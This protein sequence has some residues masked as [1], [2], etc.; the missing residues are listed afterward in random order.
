M[1]KI[2]VTFKYYWIYFLCL[3]FYSFTWY[4]FYVSEN[5]FTTY[6]NILL[7]RRFP[8]VNVLKYTFF[9]MADKKKCKQSNK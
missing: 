2:V 3:S 1:K 9:K 6:Y 7:S 5:V 4:C 8:L